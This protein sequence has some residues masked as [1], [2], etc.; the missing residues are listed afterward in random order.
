[1]VEEEY[2]QELQVVLKH[3]LLATLVTL[4]DTPSS[5]SALE[6]RCIWIHL[7]ILNPSVDKPINHLNSIVPPRTKLWNILSS[8]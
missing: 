4:V 2:M 8:T 5:G 3:T 7:D 6:N 1:M